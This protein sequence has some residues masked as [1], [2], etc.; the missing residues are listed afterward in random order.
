MRT[1]IVAGAAIVVA[2][3]LGFLA[4]GAVDDVRVCVRFVATES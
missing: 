4:G 2:G 1:A 3:L